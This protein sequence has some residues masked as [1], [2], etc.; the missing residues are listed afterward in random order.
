[1]IKVIVIATFRIWLK[2]DN[3][4]FSSYQKQILIYFAAITKQN[5]A[6]NA[7]DDRIKSIKRIISNINSRQEKNEIIDDIAMFAQMVLRTLID[8][9][10]H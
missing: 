3:I 6:D 5:E 1:M 4:L 10:T 8:H 9:V 7:N 2:Y